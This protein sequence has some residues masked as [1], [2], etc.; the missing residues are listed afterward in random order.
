M[1]IICLMS[2]LVSY[3]TSSHDVEGSTKQSLNL[4]DSAT[5]GVNNKENKNNPPKVVEE[6][7][8]I[9]IAVKRLYVL[10]ED[11]GDNLIN[12]QVCKGNERV[13]HG[14]EDCPMDFFY[15]YLCLFN[16]LLIRVPF[17]KF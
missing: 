7:S 15:M 4:V 10:G 11:M 8:T 14:K 13:Y 5:A 16:D 12:L 2:L 17:D 3:L 6:D 1:S 9:K